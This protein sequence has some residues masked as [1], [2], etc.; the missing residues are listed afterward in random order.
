MEDLGTIRFISV[1]RG[2]APLQIREQ[3]I[4]VEVPCLFS[5]DGVPSNAGDTMHDVETGLEV[6][7]YPGYIV[8]QTHAIEALQQKSPEAAEYWM[9]QGFPNHA[10]AL[11]LFDHNSAEVVKPVKTRQ[12]FWQCF[13]DA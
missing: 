6:L 2:G 12:E 9:R 13:N 5:H 11:F 10:F 4:G 3:W 8:L 7:D 1:P